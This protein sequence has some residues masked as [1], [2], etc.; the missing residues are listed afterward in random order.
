[1]KK[2]HR[3]MMIIAGSLIALG[4]VAAGAALAMG[5]GSVGEVRY[6]TE[7]ISAETISIFSEYDN[8]IVEKSDSEEITIAYPEDREYSISE[9]NGN[10]VF[11][12][13]NKEFDALEWYKH[14]NI[15][16][17][18]ENTSV[19][20]SLPKD[21]TGNVDIE[22]TGA[23]ILVS[24]ISDG[25]MSIKS[26]YGDI[27]SENT[28]CE[29]NVSSESGNVYVS[30]RGESVS[31][32]SENGNIRICASEYNVVSVSNQNGDVKV[33]DISCKALY[34]RNKSGDISGSKVTSDSVDIMNDNG[35]TKIEEIKPVMLR[36]ESR[37]GDI[38]LV[39]TGSDT[40]YSVN[41]K[42]DADNRVYVNSEYG[43]TSIKFAS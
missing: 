43:D 22:S 24:D 17:S 4:G 1:M 11:R 39:L 34:A 32:E 37:Y 6:K 25:S 21:F 26:L 9:D 19:I 42:S 23:D 14:I 20:L 12:I 38:S 16:F 36:A 10:F 28:S 5:A 18:E 2:I 29:L 15:N 35:D 13:N 30:G 27:K 31:A 7:T 3:N 40:D 8:I 41:G 33:D